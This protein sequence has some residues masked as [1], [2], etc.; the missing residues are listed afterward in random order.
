MWPEQAAPE[1]PIGYYW[2][3]IEEASI[4]KMTEGTLPRVD[5]QALFGSP[6]LER[7]KISRLPNCPA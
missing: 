2:F 7:T 5:S 1:L 4:D 6:Y 3:L